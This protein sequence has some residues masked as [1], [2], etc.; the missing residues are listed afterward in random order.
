MVNTSLI[1]RAVH[2]GVGRH[3]M[4]LDPP[5]IVQAIKHEILAQPFGVLAP[6]LARISFALFLM[7]FTG[8]R[9][10]L[11]WALWSVVWLQ[12][13]TNLA[14]I[15][16]ILAQCK[17]FASLWDSSVKGYCQ[18]AMVQVGFGY[19][20]GGKSDLEQRNVGNS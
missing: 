2:H 6:T 4:Y 20:I 17:H 11:K 14:A 10:M 19:M 9:K 5:E 16:Q 3:I 13:I 12:A 1:T 7:K 8:H 18:P 15:I